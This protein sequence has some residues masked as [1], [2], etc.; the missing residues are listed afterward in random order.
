M[1]FDELVIKGARQNNL[2]NIDLALPHDKM[3]VITGVSGSGKS[4]LA[5]DTVFAEGQWR[6]IESL[7][8]YARLFL[9]KLDRPAVDTITNIRPAIALEQRNTVRGSRSTVGTAT[10]VYDYL[11]LL[12]SKTAVP[13]CP[14][15]GTEV[16]KWAPS[17]IVKHLL[18]AHPGG[19][20][21]I[22]FTSHEPIAELKSKGFHRIMLNGEALDLEDPSF[23]QAKKVP[24]P[25]YD[26]VLDRLV[27]RDEPRF[28]DSVEGA[29]KF[30][31]GKM[32]VKLAASQEAASEG[33][34]TPELIF[35]SGNICD[36][37]GFEMPEPAPILFSFNHPIGA[38]PAC[39]GFGNVLKYSE[40][41]IVPDPYLSLS[42]GAI[43]PWQKPSYKWWARQM[44][45]ALKGTDFQVNK[46]WREL[47]KAQKELIFKGK[48]FYGINDFFEEL[49]GKRYKLHVRVFLS[50]YRK[51]E[52][53]PECRG[54][55]LRPEALAYKLNGRDIAALT[56]MPVSGL[57]GFFGALPLSGEKAQTA[58]EPLRQIG[59]KLGFLD[60][61]GLGY[62]SMNRESRTLSGGEYQRV[63]L[64]NQLASRLTGTLYV[65]DEP[66][67]G[68]HA[69]DTD[70]IAQIMRE[71]SGL[72]NTLLIV[73][74]D[75]SI[76]ESGDWI[77]ELGPGGGYLGG[78]VVFSGPK[79]DFLKAD[80]VTARYVVGKDR[81]PLP[82]ITAPRKPVLADPRGGAAES[83]I[84]VRGA[85]GNNLDNL[86]VKFPLGMLTVVSGVSGS[87]KSS[88]VV[89]T[90]YRALARHLRL[91]PED[92][93][94]FGALEGVEKIR[95]VR[96]IDQSPIGRSPRSNPV[97]Y[98][99]IFDSIRKI[100]AAQPE[101]RAHGFGPGF[102][103][104]NVPGGR[105]PACSGEGYQKLEM[106]FFE[107]LY[108][109]CEACNGRRY[110]HEALGVHYKGRDI[111]EV[112]AMTV[113]DARAFFA[114]EHQITGRLQQMIDIGLGYLRLG[115]PATTLSG[116]E[117]QR[118]KICA[119]LGL[120]PKTGFVYFLD[121]PT[122]GLHY[123]DVAA[124]LLMLRKLVE[125]GN[126]VIV[127]EHN[128]DVTA[129][130]DWVVDLGPEGGKD[131]GK[132][133]FQGPPGK[134][135]KSKSSYTG[136][137]LKKH[138]A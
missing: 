74:H 66:T 72:G 1:S 33:L 80:T 18:D 127:I 107:D 117:A 36:T 7:S 119:E 53:C 132:I 23:I 111:N 73:E 4:S 54:K 81:I 17:E 62:L 113:E 97:T 6:F 44:L 90:L 138:L 2:K 65:L 41:L 59:M 104:F 12:Y 28:A 91:E 24:A 46:P 63:N 92:P 70:R 67:V 34:A 45:K 118:L 99:K 39:K 85:K 102:F 75:K 135:L 35:S 95:G 3:I 136:E 122:V 123:R 69:R 129:A 43:E 77:V 52:V 21:F 125:G 105:C 61:V 31:H 89:E 108:I 84:G 9:E 64:S 15:C 88:L 71:L 87:G 137:Y 103:S 58:R 86:N 130:A 56:A 55:R 116:G 82:K 128:L 115:Q 83:W 51:G 8:T 29:F 126:T 37:C 30:G 78:G 112:L 120:A 96:L 10:E 57:I 19:R 79:K 93:L 50:R 38:C 131:G 100:Y 26:V 110:G 42:E 60:R 47:S 124:L 22:I 101:A 13:Y 114:G 106:Y 94:P 48:G 40:G 20:A 134:L 11:R 5:F 14:T 68:L 16:K 109:K 32:K 98:L 133:V 49:E 25:P 121:E 76:I 27:I